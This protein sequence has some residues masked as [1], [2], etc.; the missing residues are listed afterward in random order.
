MWFLDSGR[1]EAEGTRG[2]AGEERLQLELDATLAGRLRQ[3]ARRRGQP[4][5]ELARALL[6]RGL[7][8]AA[9]QAQAAAALETLTPRQQEVA[10]LIARG[11]TNHQMAEALVISPETVKTHVSNVLEKFAANSKSELRVLL[12]DLGIRWWQ[13]SSAPPTVRPPR[14]AAAGGT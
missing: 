12:L 2:P 11:Y 14:R 5:Q 7:D 10:W 3:A 6:I 4:A 8:K 13:D 9:L 1:V